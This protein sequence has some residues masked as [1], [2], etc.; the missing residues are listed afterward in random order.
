MGIIIII[1]LDSNNKFIIKTAEI[2]VFRIKKKIKNLYI[3]IRQ[4]K[5]FFKIFIYLYLI[6]HNILIFI[7]WLVKIFFFFF[8]LILSF[9]YMNDLD[10]NF[11]VCT[12]IY[13]YM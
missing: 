10:L 11:V 4:I 1:Y 3:N 9:C 6:T 7:E 13:N 8:S 5:Q 12:N 2:Y